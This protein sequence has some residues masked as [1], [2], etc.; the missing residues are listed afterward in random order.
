MEALL[1]G[2]GVPAL[3]APTASDAEAAVSANRAEV[4]ALACGGADVGTDAA[5]LPFLDVFSED[6][7]HLEPLPAQTL[8]RTRAKTA[9]PRMVSRL[10]HGRPF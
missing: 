1:P 6:V 5:P 8:S 7:E 9:V 2:A 4:G 10:T 3:P